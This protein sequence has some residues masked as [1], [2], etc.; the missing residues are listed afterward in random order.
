MKSHSLARCSHCH[1]TEMKHTNASVLTFAHSRCCSQQSATKSQ[2]H[3]KQFNPIFWLCLD[4]EGRAGWLARVRALPALD[5]LEPLA[6]LRRPICHVGLRATNVVMSAVGRQFA[7]G[8][9]RMLRKAELKSPHLAGG[10]SRTAG[11]VAITP[12]RER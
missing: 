5:R 10:R 7:A 3:E 9:W 1:H 11:N 4:G 12:S 2:Y 6:L 8:M